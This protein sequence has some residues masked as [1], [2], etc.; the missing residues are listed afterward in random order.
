[1]FVS[2]VG[3]VGGGH[4]FIDDDVVVKSNW[5]DSGRGACFCAGF[6]LCGAARKVWF[7]G[8]HVGPFTGHGCGLEGLGKS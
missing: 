6:H 3:V 2:S 4:G 1:M 8:H 5:Y 7:F